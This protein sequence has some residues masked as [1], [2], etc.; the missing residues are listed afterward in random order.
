V[1]WIL[2]YR[3]KVL[4]GQLRKELAPVILEME[5]EAFKPVWAR[6]KDP[7]GPSINLHPLTSRPGYP[8]LGLYYAKRA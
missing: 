4:Y 7:T 5:Y 8:W 6:K 1:I 2:K 3:R